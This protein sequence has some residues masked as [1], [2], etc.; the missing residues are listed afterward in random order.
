M[1]TWQRAYWTADWQLTWLTWLTS[2]SKRT[3]TFCLQLPARG[4]R[5]RCWRFPESRMFCRTKQR[6][7]IAC[8]WPGAAFR[9]ET[10]IRPANCSQHH[11]L[12]LKALY[13]IRPEGPLQ[14]WQVD[15][16]AFLSPFS[17]CCDFLL[18]RAANAARPRPPLA[19]IKMP[20]FIQEPIEPF[21]PA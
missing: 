16:C 20:I 21:I 5:L 8:P 17:L 14:P 11:M 1:F 4:G 13:V 19:S 9:T 2:Q 18:R 7:S 15:A 6:C 12:P 3:L 10:P